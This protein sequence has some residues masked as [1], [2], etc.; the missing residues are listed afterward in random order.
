MLFEN[1]VVL[2]TLSGDS[3]NISHN[4]T[5][6]NSYRWTVETKQSTIDNNEFTLGLY[7]PGE[8]IPLVLSSWFRIIGA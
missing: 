6:I 5:N 2:L 3:N 7:V 4:V 8:T 1:H